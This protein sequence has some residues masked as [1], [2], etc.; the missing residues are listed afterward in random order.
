MTECVSQLGFGF[1]PRKQM[2][3][4]FDGGR[5]SSD[6]GAVLLAE[7][8]RRLGLTAQLAACL[9]DPRQPGK[10]RQSLPDLLRQRIYQIA[11]GY[12]D[13]NDAN[14]LAS[15]PLLKACL[16]R[17]P[18]SAHDLASQPTLSRFE[19]AWD[20][21][22]LY[23]LARVFVERFVEA[24]PDPPEQIVLDL[25]ATDDP[26]HGQQEL[27]FFH[28]YYDTYCYLPLL[29]F[30]Q[31]DDGPQELVAAV[32]RPGNVHAGR[33]TVTIL[34]RLV[35]AFEEGWPDARTILRGDSGL[36]LPAVYDWCEDNGVTYAI[37]LPTNSRL[38]ALA[39]AFLQ[40][41]RDEVARTG[42]K[43]R[44]F[45]EFR[46]AADSWRQERRVILKAE[47][48]PQG[49]NPR[50]VVTNDA[51]QTP[52]EL[53]HFYTQRGDVENRIK[54]LKLDL[55]ADRTSCHRFLANQFRL[56]LHAAAFV[57]LSALREGLRG[58]E[59]AAA[60]AG[61]IRLRL[62]K[63]GVRVRETAR[64]VWLHL[65]SAYPLQPLWFLL[66]SRLRAPCT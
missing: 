19:N 65:S 30:A 18:E 47:V 22:A 49:D 13:C 45:H 42:E 20:R 34:K 17:F 21:K 51:T 2:V 33:G 24:H 54:E 55:K 29:A 12:E 3:G 56:L 38:E 64:R 6:G 60:Q 5:V 37:S 1:L 9:T 59:L 58:T 11:L 61:T 14:T 53:Y 31:A 41:A 7:A 62:L 36:A 44:H 52:A 32:L 50:F 43:A 23:R 25:D 39:E 8:D 48:T 63:V 4:R 40:A 15:D 28:G 35:A 46:Y 10:V 57:L 16:G 66:L 26:T 27:T